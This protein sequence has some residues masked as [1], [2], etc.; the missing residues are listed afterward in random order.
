MEPLPTLKSEPL[1]P[2]LQHPPKLELKPLSDSLKYAFLGLDHT[3]PVIITFNL[4]SAQESKLLDTLKK[5]RQAIGWL[6]ANLKGISLNVCMHH[7][8]LKENAKLSREM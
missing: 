5:H 8:Y 1:L 3:L 6:V 2:Y 7:I 4:I